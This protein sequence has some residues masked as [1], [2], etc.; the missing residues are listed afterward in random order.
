[1]LQFTTLFAGFAL[2]TIDPAAVIM[3]RVDPPRRKREGHRRSDRPAI[4]RHETEGEHVRNPARIHFRIALPM[5]ASLQIFDEFY[6][7]VF[8]GGESDGHALLVGV[9][10]ESV[11]AGLALYDLTMRANDLG[12]APVI[13]DT[14]SSD[15]LAVYSSSLP[16]VCRCN[17]FPPDLLATA[18]MAGFARS[19]APRFPPG[20]I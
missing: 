19:T 1:M 7:D 11:K 9:E 12:L 3:P 16:R 15:L 17:R 8:T 14:P 2:I 10:S 5:L 20:R 6:A 13:H 4:V 18:R